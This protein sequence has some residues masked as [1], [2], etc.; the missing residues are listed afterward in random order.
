M[1]MYIYINICI[2]L[3]NHGK[4][5]RIQQINIGS[6]IKFIWIAQK[7]KIDLKKKTKLFFKLL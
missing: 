4:I 3:N 2:E 6:E 1:C 7:L 5:V